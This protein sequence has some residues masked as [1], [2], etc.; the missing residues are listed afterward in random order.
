M[1][2]PWNIRVHRIREGYVANVKIKGRWYDP[3]FATGW[4]AAF[5]GALTA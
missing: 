3:G 4:W 1:T 2:A 5:L